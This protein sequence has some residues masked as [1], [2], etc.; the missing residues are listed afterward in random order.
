MP[1]RRRRISRAVRDSRG[2]FARSARSVVNRARSVRVTPKTV[3][4]VVTTAAAGQ[5]AKRINRH[6]KVQNWR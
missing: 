3:R 1:S 4:R 2:R 6:I 5:V